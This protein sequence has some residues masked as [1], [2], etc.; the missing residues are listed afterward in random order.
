[1]TRHMSN[2]KG[3][4]GGGKRPASSAID[5][6]DDD[7]KSE[8]VMADQD[9]ESTVV[10]DAKIDRTNAL[11][12]DNSQ[13]SQHSQ[14]QKSEDKAFVRSVKKRSDA[15]EHNGSQES[16]AS[17]GDTVR[18][19][20]VVIRSVKRASDG[21]LLGLV[22]FNGYVWKASLLDHCLPMTGFARLETVEKSL[23]NS[24]ES[25]E[26]LLRGANVC[27]KEMNS[28]AHVL[29]F[30]ESEMRCYGFITDPTGFQV[31]TYLGMEEVD[32]KIVAKG[33]EKS[34]DTRN[35]QAELNATCIDLEQKLRV[36]CQESQLTPIPTVY[37]GKRSLYRYTL[38]L[39]Q[40]HVKPVAERKFACLL[41]CCARVY[42]KTDTPA[43]SVVDE[44]VDDGAL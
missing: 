28:L 23:I 36:I 15:S 38:H 9:V 17:Q 34:W 5:K 11:A 26:V 3:G 29:L 35:V 8:P 32:D 37:E 19:R 20:H 42:R 39:Q 40:R 18:E 10:A 43:E 4:K 14:S 21:L 16:G 41:R 27:Q 25:E 44:M 30:S 2:S 1:M 24:S 6:D 31:I 22:V 12:E 33:S 7:S 13:Q